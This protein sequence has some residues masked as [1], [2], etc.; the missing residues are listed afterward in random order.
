MRVEQHF[1]ADE[2]EH[3]GQADLQITEVAEQVEAPEVTV[4]MDL[5]EAREEVLKAMELMEGI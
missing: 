2:G 5:K 4:T 3:N 1:Y